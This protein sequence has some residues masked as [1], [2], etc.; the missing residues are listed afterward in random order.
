MRRGCGCGWLL[1][2]GSASWVLKHNENCPGRHGRMGEWDCTVC[3]RGAMQL[4]IGICCTK[5]TAGAMGGARR[6][7]TLDGTLLPHAWGLAF[8]CHEAPYL[9]WLRR[10]CVSYTLGNANARH[11]LLPR[12]PCR[13]GT[14]SRTAASSR[15]GCRCP[16]PR[17]G[18]SRSPYPRPSPLRLRLAR[19]TGARGTGAR[20]TGARGTGP[21]GDAVRRL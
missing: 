4:L 2:V 21:C 6:C 9:P 11:H 13:T 10:C 15:R 1:G 7:G 20:G 18:T 5:G 14:T 3:R 16:T 8:G 17:A 12:A 19:G